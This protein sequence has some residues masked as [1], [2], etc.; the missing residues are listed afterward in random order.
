VPVITCPDCSMLSDL[1]VIN[2]TADEF[3][4]K[5]DFPL[6]WAS[7]AVGEQGFASD[8]DA[9]LRRLPGSSGRRSIGTRACPHCGELNEINANHCVRCE[10]EMD[11]APMQLRAEHLPTPPPYQEYAM[12]DWRLVSV[13][14]IVLALLLAVALVLVLVL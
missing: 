3:C 1:P 9:N 2:R 6:F 8:T 4:P 7:A 14:L 5:C 10:G 13:A 11:P 12:K